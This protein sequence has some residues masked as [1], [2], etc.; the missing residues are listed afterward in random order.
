MPL[1]FHQYTQQPLLCFG[2][3]H[4][5]TCP[6]ESHSVKSKTKGPIVTAPVGCTPAAQLGGYPRPQHRQE[7]GLVI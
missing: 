4:R 2:K 7:K 6:G 3:L 5:H 1:I